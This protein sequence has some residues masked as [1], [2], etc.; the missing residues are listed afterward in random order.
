MLVADVEGPVSANL[1]RRIMHEIRRVLSER[2]FRFVGEPSRADFL[3]AFSVGTRERVQIVHVPGS[4][5]GR[6]HRWRGYWEDSSV[7]T[8]SYTEGQL[9]IDILDVRGQRPVWHGTV[10][11]SIRRHREAPNVMV[12]RFVEA[13]LVEFP[14]SPTPAR[15]GP[16]APPASAAPG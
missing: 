11:G 6:G 5:V 10:A 14:P 7:H 8:H 3:V 4:V 13:I 9:A 15:P 1:E 2:G 16:S 12:A